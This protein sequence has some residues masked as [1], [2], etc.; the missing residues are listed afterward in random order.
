M[1]NLSEFSITHIKKIK[2]AEQHV[3]PPSYS[4]EDTTKTI[5]KRNQDGPREGTYRINMQQGLPQFWTKIY[6][7]CRK[8]YKRCP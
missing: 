8:K 3:I 5:Q 7:L 4:K 6:F 1:L 2:T